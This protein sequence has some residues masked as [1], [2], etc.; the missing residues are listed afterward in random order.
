M[1][2]SE[3]SREDWAAMLARA[4]YMVSKLRTPAR[5]KPWV[6][7]E[8]RAERM[9]GYFRDRVDGKPD[10]V[11]EFHDAVLEFCD[12]Y[13]QDLNWLLFGDPGTMINDL[14]ARSKRAAAEAPSL[15]SY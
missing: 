11:E 3:L 6:V 5:C 4:R 12:Y 7:D 14:A 8:D 1:K 9:L 2:A 10:D 13:G 15:Y